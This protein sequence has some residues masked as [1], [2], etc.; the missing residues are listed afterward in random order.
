MI[1]IDKEFRNAMGMH[2]STTNADTT[3]SEP[4]TLEKLL[5]IAHRMGLTEV[6]KCSKQTNLAAC[7]SIRDAGDYVTSGLIPNYK[8]IMGIP[9]LTDERVPLDVLIIEQA[10]RL[11]KV[12]AL[13]EDAQQS[14][15]L[16]ATLRKEA[17][18]LDIKSRNFPVR[19][20]DAFNGSST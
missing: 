5:Y 18:D 15:Q 2:G 19:R 20:A 1:D 11:V 17:G 13:T 14:A 4:L 8:S 3:S 7:L 9:V 16:Y 6:I 10:G 12:V